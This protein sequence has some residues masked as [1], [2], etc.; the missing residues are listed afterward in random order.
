[1]P[2][3]IEYF[4]NDFKD[5]SIDRTISIDKTT[6]DGSEN[7][8][9]EI[10]ERVRCYTNSDVRYLTYYIPYTGDKLELTKILLTQV[11]SQRR[12]LQDV[13]ILSGFGGDINIGESKIVYSNRIYLYIEDDTLLENSKSELENIANSYDFYLTIRSKTYIIKKMEIEKPIAFISHDL[14]D[15]ELIAKRLALGLNSRLCYVWYDEYSLKIGDSLRESIEDGIKNAQKCILIL[16]KNYLNNPGWGKR[17]FDSIFTREMIYNERIV[18]PIWFD[19]T[20]EEIYEYS[21]SLADTFAL[22]WPSPQNKNEDVYKQEIEQIISKIHS[23]I[24]SN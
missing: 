23:A 3:L 2:S 9:I 13:S 4:N 5:V 10:S 18:L 19:V 6:D 7:V 11:C 8:T 17:E 15:K 14:R 1:M 16:T 21:P 24:I 12:Y 22:V 20:K